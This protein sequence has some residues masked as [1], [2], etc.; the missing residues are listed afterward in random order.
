MPVDS[1]FCRGRY[2]F[3]LLWVSRHNQIAFQEDVRLPQRTGQ[4]G[5]IGPGADNKLIS[6]ETSGTRYSAN[7]FRPGGV[8]GLVS[9]IPYAWFSLPAAA[10]TPFAPGIKANQGS[11]LQGPG[12]NGKTITCLPLALIVS[13]P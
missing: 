12:T 6:L 11:T 5:R 2:L 1:V 9:K 10:I 4:R 8:N 7:L 3:T 13:P